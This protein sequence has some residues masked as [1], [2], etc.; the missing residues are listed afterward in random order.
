MSTTAAKW[1]TRR[2]WSSKELQL[3]SLPRGFCAWPPERLWLSPAELACSPQPSSCSLFLFA[4]DSRQTI[5]RRTARRL[6]MRNA[7][8]RGG[9]WGEA[10]W[11]RAGNGGTK[12]AVY[13]GLN[14]QRHVCCLVKLVS[15]DG[16]I[17]R[18]Q[19]YMAACVCR[20][21]VWKEA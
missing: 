21:E 14:S 19:I 9:F 4:Y 7:K 6:W 11:S 8:L 3:V 13:D 15:F 12:K 17:Q 20:W 16:V 18:W 1:K 5:L 2:C 10:C